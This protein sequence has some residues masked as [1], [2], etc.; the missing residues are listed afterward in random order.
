M[1]A[2][3]VFN[4]SLLFVMLVSAAL[5]VRAEPAPVSKY[6]METP[7]NAFDFG[8][9]RLAQR[10]DMPDRVY[11]PINR[12]GR[13]VS[14]A[15]YDRERGYIVIASNVFVATSAMAADDAK[16]VCRFAVADARFYGGVDPKTGERL[17]KDI[18]SLAMFFESPSGSRTGEP[19]NFEQELMSIVEF[20]IQVYASHPRQ[21]KVERKVECVAPLLGT[22]IRFVG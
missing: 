20:R 16:E 15:N 18:R 8:L 14:V 19:A 5:S 9:F 12:P 7:L 17:P 22:D 2:R 6:L 3:S 4:N 13:M 10:Y 11:P 21:S 1:R